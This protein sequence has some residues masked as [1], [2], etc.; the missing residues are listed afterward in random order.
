MTP[1]RLARLRQELDRLLALPGEQRTLRLAELHGAD[2][3]LAA[4][5]TLALAD[6]ERDD[7]AF[8]P[9]LEAPPLQAAEPAL[10][11]GLRLGPWQL[12]QPLGEG[13][14]GQVWLAER[15][16]GAYEQRVAIKVPSASARTATA[17]ARF[18]RERALLAEFDHPGIARL[19]DGG[20]TA[21]GRPWFAMEHVEGV[22]I[23]E[24]AERLALDGRGRVRLLL[25]ACRVLAAA[26]RRRIVHRD[27]KPQNL[28]VRA[29]GRVALVDFGIAAV[30]D[31]PRR[32][33]GPY[34]ATPRYAAPEQLRGEP[35]TTA[36]DVYSLGV[37][38]TELVPARDADLDAVFAAATHPDPEHR[39]PN[40]AALADELERWLAHRPVAARPP[41]TAHRLRLF[42]RRDPRSAAAVA[43][44]AVAVL[45]LFVTALVLWRSERGERRRADAAL[46]AEARKHAQVRALVRDLVSGV[47][48]RIQALP[49]A[50]P[51]RAFLV[52][53]AE[54]HLAQLAADAALDADLAHEVGGVHLRLADV[55]G[56]RTQGHVGDPAGAL[57][58]TTAAVELSRAW[59]QRRP[60]E[61]RWPLLEAE[62]RRLRG[63]LHR[64]RGDLVEARAEYEAARAVLAAR[65]WLPAAGE[66]ARLQA[67]LELQLGKV[68][69]AEGAVARGTE[70]IEAAAAAFDRLRAAEPGSRQAR[71]DAAHAYSE[72]AYA[73]TPLGDGTRT[74]A[75][76]RAAH[77]Q[78]TALAA[79]FP[80][81]AQLARDRL[82][83][84]VELALDDALAGR[85]DAANR[86]FDAA[87]VE[88]RALCEQDR[89]NVLAERLLQRTLLRGARLAAAL[90]D[91]AVAA[92]RY[93]EAEPKVR[94][95]L[96][97]QPGDREL[98]RDLAEALAARAE[99]ER[100]LGSADGVRSAY[101][102]ALALLP[103][104]EAFARGDHFAGNLLTLTWVGL[105]NLALAGGD[106]AAARSRLLAHRDAAAAWAE[107][108][109]SLHW[110]LRHLGALEYA[111]GTACET[112]AKDANLPAPQ[113][114]LHLD[115][116]LGAYERGLAST[117]RL[118]S[119]GRLAPREKAILGFFRTDVERVRTA[120]AALA[121]P[122]ET[123]P[124]R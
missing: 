82:E 109:E 5:V 4:A 122:A 91:H 1:E 30:L 96:A 44:L 23:D 49:G 14:M 43:G 2:A 111:L 10:T 83:V 58:S 31:D 26:H 120:R 110:P 32:G 102:E 6:A 53:R 98:R 34:L 94:A 29:D 55:R 65:T 86:R 25:D 118:G 124:G 45:G 33:T 8:E 64:A 71:R 20:W 13:G 103:H 9:L 48:D 95:A 80:H 12:V 59:A 41:T 97:A 18:E 108:F 78:W 99:A 62:G 3:D 100:L 115:E 52:E 84:A 37:I 36:A 93:R 35:A 89:Q 54:A 105:G 81:D 113:R 79:E 106:H 123:P 39:P 47:H 17:F 112:L 119:A 117:E 69:V 68:D 40:A 19:V 46:S 60:D 11:A 27:L 63:D 74:T 92:R 21:P 121:G 114:V 116:A 72:L 104:D 51:V 87:L 76:W 42:A 15:A 70:R 28:L 88:V 61:A 107:R 75:A 90:A 22:R 38:G 24:H 57:R 66:H 56:A 77:A 85:A 7:P 101:E 67:I 50:V 16:D 73:A